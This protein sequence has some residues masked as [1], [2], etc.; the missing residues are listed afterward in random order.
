[1]CFEAGSKTRCRASNVLHSLV[2]RHRRATT[3][4]MPPKTH[5]NP[6]RHHLVP[7][8][9]L[10]RFSR[11][12]QVRVVT[13]DLAK[14]FI[15][16]IADASVRTHYYSVD[17]P[18]GTRSSAV[19]GFLSHVEGS[20][21]Q[22]MHDL[23]DGRLPNAKG[24]A[25]FARF[26]ALQIARTQDDRRAR[27][28]AGTALARRM[29]ELA[30]ID[31]AAGLLTRKLGREPTESEIDAKRHA[32]RALAPEVALEHT[33]NSHIEAMLSMAD[34]LVDF[35]LDRQWSIMVFRDPILLTGDA[36]VVCYS[37]Q[38]EQGFWGV[39]VANA[40]FVAFPVSTR[41]ALVMFR[42]D[43]GLK[44]AQLQGTRLFAHGMN[45]QLAYQCEELIFHH[46][47]IK[48]EELI[49]LPPKGPRVL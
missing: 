32:M 7:K 5:K 12:D 37:P 49:E 18:D 10:R 3:A 9:Y 38:S 4:N 25:T 23:D 48:H 43:V 39:G 40:G 31:W 34:Y 14:S 45:E 15:A 44:P 8:F 16:N 42:A 6:A 11:R 28:E 19:E 46:P 22:V 47:D 2:T 1:M 21:A 35:L 30:P 17:L 13:R 24:R 29:L 36:P 41:R 26:L 33:Q 27:D 20:A